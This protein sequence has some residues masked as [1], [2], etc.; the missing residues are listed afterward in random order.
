MS[1]FLPP[2]F[3]STPPEM[4]GGFSPPPIG[5]FTPPPINGFLPPALDDGDDVLGDGDDV[6]G[7]H[8]GLRRHS[9]LSDDNN[10][11]LT[12]FSEKMKTLEIDKIKHLPP[13]EILE[14]QKEAL[15]DT[16]DI[17]LSINGLDIKTET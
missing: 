3:S 1:S 9:D 10:Y 6:I 4:D 14:I 11:D 13:R 12:G 17:F 15:G 16:D 5:N 8:F 2:P 7:D